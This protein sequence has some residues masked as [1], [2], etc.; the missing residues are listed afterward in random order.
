MFHQ[1]FDFVKNELNTY[2]NLKLDIN[3]DTLTYLDG[4]NNDPLEFEL[5]KIT[6]L[7]VNIE[8]ER[9][10]RQ[11]DRYQT[12]SENGKPLAIM[13][14][15]P[16][17]LH[18]LFIAR[19]KDYREG[20][21]RLSLLVQFFQKRP[22]FTPQSYPSLGPTGMDKLTS[23]LITMSFQQQNE[24]W[25][26]LKSPYQPSILYKLGITLLEEKSTAFDAEITDLQTN[27]IQP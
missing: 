22:V 14:P 21:K 15:V 27:V 2:F 6:P 3:T 11:A 23:E 17:K 24:L 10:M 5:D 16:L 18:V 19:F 25:G 8:E 13:P 12:Q 9:R 26:A 1:V 7:L 4:S 20:L